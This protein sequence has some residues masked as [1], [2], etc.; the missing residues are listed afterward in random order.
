M[1]DRDE[2]PH[3][4]VAKAASILRLEP[5]AL[6]TMRRSGLDRDASPYLTVVE[7]AAFLRLKPRTL[8]NMRCNGVGPTFCKH[9]GRI[10]YRYQDV[11]AWSKASRRR[12]T[13]E[14][15]SP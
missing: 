1:S 5:R 6:E 4:T 7:T 14:K 15:V 3:L 2:S 10:F 11:V 12:S 8:D 13:A 9:G